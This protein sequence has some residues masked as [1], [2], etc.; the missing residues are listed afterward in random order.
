MK[1]PL[2]LAERIVTLRSE[3]RAAEEEFQKLVGGPARRGPRKAA[4]SSQ[5]SKVPVAERVRNMLKDASGPL[6]F[7]EIT[8][9]L[10]D[11]KAEAVKSAL[12]KARD[13]GTVG[14]RGFKYY[15]K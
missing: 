2:A 6:A 4:F 11:V 7:G 1:D 10:G 12:K 8:G 14:F 15:W 13:G 3:L 9:A 5:E